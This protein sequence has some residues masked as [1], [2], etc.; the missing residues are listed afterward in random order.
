[1]HSCTARFFTVSICALM[2]ALFLFT[3]SA[4]TAAT[5]KFHFEGEV[6]QTDNS[7]EMNIGDTLSFDYYIDENHPNQATGTDAKDNA[8]YSADDGI[9][10]A[11]VYLNG[12][13]ILEDLPGRDTSEGSTNFISINRNYGT[14]DVVDWKATE[15]STGG[16]KA[17]ARFSFDA[18]ALPEYPDL[19][20]LQGLSAPPGA[21][22]NLSQGTDDYSAPITQYTT[23]LVAVPAPAG[24][25]LFVSGL[26]GLAGIARKKRPSL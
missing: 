23:S 2:A 11:N 8:L 12:S 26:F 13:L 1:M 17:G 19:V 10:L 24:L 3:T 5:L 20:T 14:S 15:S 21:R 25:I 7:T 16:W 22:I 4:A 18:G 9:I 6:D